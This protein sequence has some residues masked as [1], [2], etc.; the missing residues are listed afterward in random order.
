VFI[1]FYFKKTNLYQYII[2]K[3]NSLHMI[4]ITYNLRSKY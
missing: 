4:Y 2:C 3:P 1:S